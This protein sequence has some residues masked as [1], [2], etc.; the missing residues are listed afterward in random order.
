MSLLLRAAVGVFADMNKW[1]IDYYG[2]A[3][4]R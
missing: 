2:V 4:S 3:P 1:L